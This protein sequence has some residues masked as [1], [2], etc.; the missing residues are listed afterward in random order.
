MSTFSIR[1]FGKIVIVPLFSCSFLLGGTVPAQ[2]NAVNQKRA[3]QLASAFQDGCLNNER[4]MR[5]AFKAFKAN[6]FT[7]DEPF[8]T[9]NNSSNPVAAASVR[10][11]LGIKSPKRGDRKWDV[12]FRGCLLSRVGIFGAEVYPLVVAALKKQGYKSVKPIQ[13]LRGPTDGNVGVYERNGVRFA[14]E[15]AQYSAK[16]PTISSVGNIRFYRGNSR[17]YLRIIEAN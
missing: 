6:G 2:S 17:T 1:R 10:M 15:F 4:S 8:R 16:N 5:E 12:T 3:A 13:A 9:S 7:Y 14:V 11:P